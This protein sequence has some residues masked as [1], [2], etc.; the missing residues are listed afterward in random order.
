MK[1]LRLIA[2]LAVFFLCSV[3]ETAPERDYYEVLGVA[4]HADTE[5]IKK[6]YRKLSMLYHPDRNP[7][8]AHAETQFK[9]AAKAY[10]VLFDTAKRQQYDRGFHFN[11]PNGGQPWFG[12]DL[13][14]M[15]EPGNPTSV[16]VA[17]EAFLYH[18]E[19]YPR[20]RWH[21]G[22]AMGPDAMYSLKGFLN[23][24]L[25][26]FMKRAS[27]ADRARLGHALDGIRRLIETYH[28]DWARMGVGL[29]FHIGPTRDTWT[30]QVWDFIRA[31]SRFLLNGG[32]RAC[33]WEHLGS[34]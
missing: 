9:E 22:W 1:Y 19:N 2:L 27:P 26:D 4:R 17:V 5:T 8:D 13:N 24:R 7:G 34:R 28:T 29:N 21:P 12:H 32:N 14:K 6:A 33:E 15:Y 23:T 10:E 16:V 25:E 31:K 18:F 3:S 20:N 11:F 30:H